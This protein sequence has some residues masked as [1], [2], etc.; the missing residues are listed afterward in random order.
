GAAF[1][2]LA[3][4]EATQKFVV[5]SSFGYGFIT[6]FENFLAGKKAGKQL[7]NADKAAS[8]LPPAAVHDIATDFVVAISSGGNLL[9]FLP[10]SCPSSTRARATRFCR[11]RQPN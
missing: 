5:A 3:A 6:A 2:G 4:G 10:R 8:I 9:A 1:V 7:I 11:F